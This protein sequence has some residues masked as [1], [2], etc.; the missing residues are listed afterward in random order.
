MKKSY[1]LKI[2]EN[3]LNKLHVIANKNDISLSLLLQSIIDSFLNNIN[4]NDK[5]TITNI[6]NIKKE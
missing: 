1:L 5:I 4:E 6:L 3:T 2:D